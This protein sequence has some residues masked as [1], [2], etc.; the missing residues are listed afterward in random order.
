MSNENKYEM[1]TNESSEHIQLNDI[2][3][4]CTECSSNIEIFSINNDK[5]Y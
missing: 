1:E 2:Y 5:Y 4:N 3:Y